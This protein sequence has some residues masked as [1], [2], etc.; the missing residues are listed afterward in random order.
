MQHTIKHA[1][2]ITG[3]GVHSG[4][5]VNIR[6][7]PAA[8]NTGVVFKRV[9][10]SGNI[11]IPATYQYIQNTKSCT[12]LSNNGASISTVE[13]LLSAF[14]G[15]QVDNAVVTVD[16]AELPVLDGSAMVFADAIKKEGVV[17]QTAP[18]NILALDQEIKIIDGDQYIIAKPYSGLRLNCTITYDHPLFTADTNQFIF[19]AQVEDYMALCAP[20][21]TYGFLR[22][23]E[24]LLKNNLA[25]GAS[26]DN[27]VVFADD[28]VKNPDGLRFPNECARHKVLDLMGDLYLFGRPILAEIVAYKPSHS[29]NAKLVNKLAEIYDIAT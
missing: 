23:Y 4:Q 1:I 9:D 5:Q 28:V 11:L 2:T 18:R 8:E 12:T 26:L 19:D 29:L 27:T 14:A 6:I 16:A 20:A 3:I 22:D 13:H 25:K 15:L 21:R 7:I 24:Y 17:Q 10:L